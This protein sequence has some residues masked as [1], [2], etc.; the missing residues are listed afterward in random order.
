ME[1]HMVVSLEHLVR[2]HDDGNDFLLRIMRRDESWDYHFTPEAKV[3]S[4]EKSIITSPMLFRM[5]SSEFFLE[6]ILK[7]NSGRSEDFVFAGLASPTQP[8]RRP[9]QPG[10]GDDCCHHGQCSRHGKKRP[11]KRA[12]RHNHVA[13]PASHMAGIIGKSRSVEEKNLD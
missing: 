9:H 7:L 5:Q 12:R 3:T 10:G 6:D 2:F 8:A 1:E 13:H 4:K 11:E